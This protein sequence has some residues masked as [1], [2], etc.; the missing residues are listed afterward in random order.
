MAFL[1]AGLITLYFLDWNQMRGP[2]GRYASA[3]Y[4]REVR[5]DGNLNVNLFRWQPHV[6]VGGLYIGNPG[7]VAQPEGAS[8]NQAVVEFRLVPAIFGH[9]KLPLVALNQPHALIVRDAN[10]RNNWDSDGSG[11]GWHIPPINRFLVNDGHL[12][13]DDRVRKLKFTGTITSQEVAGGANAFQLKG[14]GMLNGNKFL[15][16]IHGGPLINVDEARPYAFTA[17]IR[18]GDTKAMLD[19]SITHP[20]HLD[21]LAATAN[22]SGNSLADLYDLTGLALPRTPPYHISG[23]LSRNGAIFQMHQLSGMLGNSDLHGD[24]TVDVSGP[25]PYLRGGLTSRTL[26]FDDLGA[27]IGG[28]KYDPAQEARLLPDTLL[29]VERLNQMDADV[30]YTAASIKSRDFPLR[31]LVT[32]IGLKDGVLDLKPLSFAFSQGKLS[33]S[34]SID[35]KRP[36]AP[37]THV[38][39]RVTDIHVEHFIKSADKPV[40]GV[41]EARAVLTGR[42][43]SVHKVAATATGNATAVIPSG[44]IRQSLAEW[45]GIDVINALLTDAKSDTNVRCAMVHFG[46]KDGVL[47]SQQFIFDTEPV[48]VLGDGSINLGDETIA[49]RLQGK[50]KHFELFRLRAPIMVTGSLQHPDLGVGTN[51]LVTQGAIGAGLALASPFAA[52]LA[53]IDPGLAD[54]AN[55]AGLLADAKAQGAPAPKPAAAPKGKS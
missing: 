25:K 48:L 12:Q 20:F 16:E 39:A 11:A 6:E 13:I 45:M 37:V 54:D 3:H 44:H 7:W 29:H 38:D 53:F 42:G 49:M 40:E 33:G 2:I 9:L 4:G 14:D 51:A 26:D 34:L 17:D 18:A 32:H 50:P 15:A 8:V 23:Q 27:V 46:A 21:Q 35:A 43:N 19:G 28:G 22:F 24:L 31:G 52:L 10:G 47:T 1:I 55:C 36:E 41:V 30:A 5:I